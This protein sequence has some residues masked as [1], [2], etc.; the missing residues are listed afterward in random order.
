MN[1]KCLKCLHGASF[2]HRGFRLGVDPSG[3]VYFTGTNL[4]APGFSVFRVK[5]GGSFDN[6]Y[7]AAANALSLAVDPAGRAWSAGGLMSVAD[8]SGRRFSSM[9]HPARSPH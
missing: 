7:G 1:L 9:P 8:Q 3:A 6:L 5:D 4:G 2:A